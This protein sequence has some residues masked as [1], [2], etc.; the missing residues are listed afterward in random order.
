MSNALNKSRKIGAK[1]EHLK[2]WISLVPLAGT[3]TVEWKVRTKSEY[4][5]FKPK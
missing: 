3:E 1:H 5:E 4:T 2:K